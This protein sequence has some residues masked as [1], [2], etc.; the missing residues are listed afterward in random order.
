MIYRMLIS[1]S[2]VRISTKQFIILLKEKVKPSFQ[3]HA[4]EK[5]L[6]AFQCLKESC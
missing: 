5:S 3:V 6:V 1:R 2:C 4:G